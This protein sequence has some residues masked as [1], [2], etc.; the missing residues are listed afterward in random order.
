MDG[1]LARRA[2]NPRF[3]NERRVDSG[4]TWYLANARSTNVTKHT[5]SN[6]KSEDGNHKMSPHR[7]DD[8]GAKKKKKKKKSEN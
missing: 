8:D 6:Y 3:Q 5:F 4:E 2:N 1:F 7:N